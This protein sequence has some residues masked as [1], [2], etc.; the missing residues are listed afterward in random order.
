[1]VV[2]FVGLYEHFL[3]SMLQDFPKSVG[4]RFLT[5]VLHREGIIVRRYKLNF[6]H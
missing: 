3:Q 5:G 1:M 6:G 4:Y 2:H